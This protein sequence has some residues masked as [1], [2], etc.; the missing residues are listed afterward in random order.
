MNNLPKLSIRKKN[1]QCSTKSLEGAFSY[2]EEKPLLFKKRKTINRKPLSLP[3]THVLVNKDE[4]YDITKEYEFKE[5]LGFG[6][7][8][9]V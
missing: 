4:T 7:Y 2:F 3:L 1:S 9:Q 8:S 5:L 6:M